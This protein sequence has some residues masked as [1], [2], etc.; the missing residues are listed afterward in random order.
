[1]YIGYHTN[2]YGIWND[3]NSLKI[4]S[5]TFKP[6]NDVKHLFRDI[7]SFREKAV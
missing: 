5:K 4:S 6:G 2:A 7:E 1:M 3:I